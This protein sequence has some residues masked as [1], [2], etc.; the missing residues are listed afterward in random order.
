MIFLI[1]LAVV[2]MALIFLGIGIYNNLV[3]LANQVSRAWSNIDVVLKQRFDE[4]GQLIQ[5]VEQYVGHEKAMIQKVLDARAHYGTASS[6]SEKIG[7]SQE[8]SRAL[9]G[10][11]A[12]G[13]AYPDLRS[14]ESFVALQQRISALENQISDRRELYNDAATNFNTRIVQIPDVL[15]ANML[16]FKGHLLFR[17]DASEIVKPKL[18]MNL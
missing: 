12:L 17:A 11:F 13:E 8:M 5:V 10:V 3:S 15:F 1:F 18:K 2:A 7:A 4:I 14:N 9:K 16:G 6:I